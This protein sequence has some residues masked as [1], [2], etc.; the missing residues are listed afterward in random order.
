MQGASNRSHYPLRLE[1]APSPS[2]STDPPHFLPLQDFDSLPDWRAA[3][4]SMAEGG[5]PTSAVSTQRHARK[6]STLVAVPK[7]DFA[8]P[9]PTLTASAGLQIPPARS[10][11]SPATRDPSLNSSMPRLSRDVA[12]EYNV[13]AAPYIPVHLRQINRAPAHDFNTPALHQIDYSTYVTTFA[14]QSF[15][16]EPLDVPAQP[17]RRHAA[18]SPLP[19]SADWYLN[20]FT[21]LWSLEM[22]AKEQEHERFALY[23]VALQRIRFEDDEDL[24]ALCIPGIREDSPL[25][26]KGDTIQLRQLWVNPVGNSMALPT[27]NGRPGNISQPSF[28]GVQYNASVYNV[29]RTTEIVYLRA[30]GLPDLPGL[31]LLALVVN[32]MFPLKLRVLRACWNALVFV[33]RAL[34]TRRSRSTP[35][36]PVD[37]DRRIQRE[38]NHGGGDIPS[39]SAQQERN[40]NQGT[41][42]GTEVQPTTASNNW[43]E[44]IL[45]PVE[46]AGKLQTELR[47]PPHRGYFDP[48]INFEQ[49]HAVG[50]LVT[51]I[52]GTLPYLISGPPG[53]G[54]TKTLVEI[55]MQ[56]LESEQ[57]SHILI[58]APSDPAADT[59]ALRLK[60]YLNPSQLLR[61][62]G[63]WRTDIEV[64][65]ELMPY[66]YMER[67][68]FY[69]PPFQNLM[70]FDVVVTSCRDAS[71]LVD[72]RLTN[73]D[74]WTIEKNMLSA[75]HPEDSAPSP[76]KLHWG[77]LLIDEAAQATELDVLPGISV[78]CPPAAYSQEYPQPR[79]AMAGD[80]NQLGPRTASRDP[81]F[82]TSL[83]ARLFDRPLYKNHPLS[84]SNMKPSAG[85]PVLKK[86]MLPI[87]YP[88]FTNLIRNYRS[89]PAILSV[90]SSLFYNDTL[91]PE[92]PAAHTPLQASSLWQG[93][94]WPV[95]FLPH[96]GPDEIERDGGGWYNINEAHIAC[97]VAQRLV[98]ESKVPQ[99]DICIMS[100]FAAQ[101]K[102]LRARIRSSRYG[103]GAGLWDINIGPL[104][105]FQGLERRVVII[106]TTRTREQFLE[107]DSQRGLGMIYQHQKMNVALTRAKEGLFVI[108]N[109]AVLRQ[110]KHWNAWLA[111]CWRNA[112]VWDQSRVWDGSQEGFGGEKLG[113]LER[114]LLAK[115][116]QGERLLGASS[117][118]LEQ[119]DDAE[120]RAWTEGLREA[121]EEE[122]GEF[123]EEY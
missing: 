86:S 102:L 14:G 57:V 81:Q 45:F 52:Y 29:N 31:A 100:P 42:I 79:F 93:R 78:V 73:A 122:D 37:S 3:M 64:P 94:R 16:P 123:D 55:A 4:M 88:P 5:G 91:M 98:Y 32:V 111:F 68:M 67:D 27:Q 103:G 77:A 1:A 51:N 49:G 34:H 117:T 44:T 101:V 33:D 26:E 99:A 84:R 108:G 60:Q 30:K 36:G 97:D 71:I 70:A 22:S 41:G 40:G 50:D 74:L 19:L 12:K 2:D 9:K 80:E 113:V 39:T 11:A 95:L 115:E 72:A 23:Q 17:S 43:L 120:Y 112:L 118:S 20:Y 106:C 46:A 7:I 69:L 54:K 104:E 92:A 8:K 90:P 47:G 62:N 119:H 85:P 24:F 116:K 35:D 121:L 6:P 58:C 21:P 10:S 66:S 18:R 83:F 15:R 63:P 59:L 110:D 75:F 114:A 56:L 61:L 109:P 76:P 28:T 38:V 48:D 82:S 87:L 13:Y 105:A 53:T 65:Q 96:T 107:Q 25:V 89:H